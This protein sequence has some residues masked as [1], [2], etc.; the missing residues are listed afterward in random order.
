M[1]LIPRLC[2]RGYSTDAN[3]G[4]LL[5][6]YPT[7]KNATPYDVLGLKQSNVKQEELKRRFYE[8]AKVYH[9]D[10]AHDALENK[11]KE[12]RFKRI[13]AAYA[14][15]KNPQT[16]QNYDNYGIGWEDNSS[17]LYR[18]KTAPQAGHYR[19]STY[20]TWEDRWH[21]QQDF[22][23]GYYTDNTWRDMGPNASNME[24][25]RQNRRTI[26]LTLL[27][28]TGIYTALQFAHIIFYDDYIGGTYRESL[29]KR[30]QMTERSRKDLIDA[31]ENYGFGDSKEERIQRFLWFRHLSWLLGEDKRT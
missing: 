31:R 5:K 27:L 28:A 19:P 6:L 12:H 9:P 20:G 17:S 25:F 21:G 16:R 24:T 3:V 22:G 1:M 14:L 30:I 15:L 8:L 2:R 18:P 4:R 11:E 23:F 13:L 29:V 7:F 10:S 26:F